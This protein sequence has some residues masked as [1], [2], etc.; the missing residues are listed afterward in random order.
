[1]SNP[2]LVH[3]RNILSLLVKDKSTSSFGITRILLTALAP[4]NAILIVTFLDT[5][6]Q[7][8]LYTMYSL[9]AL[10]YYAELGLGQVLTQLV[11]EAFVKSGAGPN[12]PTLLLYTYLQFTLRSGILLFLITFLISIAAFLIFFDQSS[13]RWD[14]LMGVFAI[15]SIS[16]SISIPMVLLHAYL[17]ACNRNVLINNIRSTET[18]V[19]LVVL[20]LLLSLGYK[21]FAF[22]FATMITALVAVALV[23]AFNYPFFRRLLTLPKPP[24]E[25]LQEQY[26]RVKGAIL[27]LQLRYAQSWMSGIFINALVVPLVFRLEGKEIAGQLGF[28]MALVSVILN[29]SVVLV[30]S[31]L[32]VFAIMNSQG[33]LELLVQNYSMRHYYSLLLFGIASVLLLTGLWADYVFFQFLRNRFLAFPYFILLLLI[34]LVRLLI[35]N[36]VLFVRSFKVEPFVKVAW[37]QAL[38]SILLLPAG[39]YFLGIGGTLAALL[40]GNL[41]NLS[42]TS[43]IFQRYLA[44]VG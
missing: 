15:L 42:L 26:Q 35:E 40:A 31:Q 44:K 25:I 20:V 37:A 22:A 1:M 13:L 33:N 12:K 39:T 3:F 23:V 18:L 6:E 4:I 17:D 14:G 21:L 10:G 28:S 19:R 32:P 9:V 11:S 38:L 43:R 30:T 36:K 5:S 34:N 8:Y 2:L 7:G 29:F 27:P 16:T 41:L 24:R